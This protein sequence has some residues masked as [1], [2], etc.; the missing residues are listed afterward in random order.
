MIERRA[1][2]ARWVRHVAVAV[3]IL[4]GSLLVGIAGY[5]GFAGLT[6]VDAFMNSAMLLGGMGP[7]DELPND[8]AKVFAGL[9]A[10]YAGIV[11]LVAIAVVAAPAVHRFL[12]RLHLDEADDPGSGDGESGLRRKP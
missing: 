1:F 11:F 3:I 12:H 5:M 2:I 7:V 6:L 9:Y 10:L 4:G 8:G